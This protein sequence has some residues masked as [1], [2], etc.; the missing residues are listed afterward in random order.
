MGI[1]VIFL[2]ISL[3]VGLI[4]Y[5]QVNI[6]G[7]VIRADNKPLGCASVVLLQDSIALSGTTTSKTGGFSLLFNF[8]QN[9]IYFLRISLVGYVSFQT[10]FRYPDSNF[11]KIV[12]VENKNILGGVTITAKTP[13]VVRKSDRYIINVENSLLA[14]G[15][16]GLEVLQK[17]PG[18]WVDNN[19]GIHIKG[20]QPANVMI[21]DVVQ[22]MSGDDLAEFLKS[23]KSEDISK[24]EVIAN[25]P[26]EFEAVGSG[27][28]I[29]IILKKP[30][31][32]GLN[33][34]VFG[35][36][37]QQGKTPLVSMGTSIDYKIKNLYLS[38][39]YSYTNDRIDL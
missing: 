38:G 21:N 24:I 26:A 11:N 3:S 39:S 36:Y 22:R 18:I 25:P 12:L 28:I 17:S 32:D 20:N 7:R 10:S 13:L 9:N 33:G 5:S 1:K 31:K 8:Q 19:G 30:R 6:T 34:S 15:N 16:S 23:I 4:V 2:A 27:G 35:R 37:N 14:N 29:H